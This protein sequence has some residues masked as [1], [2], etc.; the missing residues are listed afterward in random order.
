[1]LLLYIIKGE[2]APRGGGLR[3]DII[4]IGRGENSSHN[5][6]NDAL[7][8]LDLFGWMMIPLS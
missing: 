6:P 8:S 7:L 5:E 1:L 3:D 2:T 4:V